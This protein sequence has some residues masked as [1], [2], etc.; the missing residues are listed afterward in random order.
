MIEAV[1]ENQPV[2][3]WT[4]RDAGLI[5]I[6]SSNQPKVKMNKVE[7]TI[8]PLPDGLAANTK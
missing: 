5:E 1:S 2:D 8:R 7:E 4:A 3:Q 6:K